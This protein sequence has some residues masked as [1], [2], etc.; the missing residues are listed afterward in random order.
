MPTPEPADAAS[1]AIAID[2]TRSVLVQA[3]AGSGKTTLLT[4]R[5]L[6]LL[7]R[8]EQPER[9]LALTFTRKAA[10]E[11][12]TRAL[13]A[14][15]AASRGDRGDLDLRS[16][17]LACA[18][19]RHLMERRID[20]S[21]NPTRLR[22][23]T[24]DGF[25]AWLAAQLPVTA[26][27]GGRI[28]VAED[29]LPYYQEAAAR[30][31]DG[32]AGPPF[33]RAIDRALELNDERWW[34]ARD[35]IAS[36][37]GSR[38]RWLEW[39]AGR[40]H[41][42]AEFDEQ[43]E[44]EVRAALD[45]DLALL[46]E[47]QLERAAALIGAERLPEL[48]RLLAG[49][50]Q[51]LPAGSAVLGSWR[52]P[53]AQLAP[54]AALVLQWRE[55]ANLV[56]TG[57]N[58]FRKPTALNVTLGFPPGC[59]DK[60][61]MAGLIEELARIPEA[62]E[63]LAAVRQLPEDR[64]DDAQWERVRALSRVLILGAAELERVFRQHAVADF[65][66]VF[67]A[68]LQ[69]LGR[70]SEP[71][72]LALLLDHRIEHILVDEFQDTS[73]AQLG[74]FRLLTAG[75]ESGD[76]RTFFC[77]GDPMQSI[78]GFREAEVR[79]FLDLA[80][81]GLGAVKLEPVRLTSNFRAQAPLV[82]WVNATF[83]RVFPRRDDRHRGAIAFTPA[84][85]MAR[86]DEAAAG[87]HARSFDTPAH[88]AAFIAATLAGM[89][90]E[91]GKLRAAI[92]VRQ[93]AHALPIIEA[94]GARGLAFRALD[95]GR[96][97]DTAVV[98]DII[99]LTRALLHA[100]D[101]IAWFALLRGPWVGLDLADLAT[102]AE[103]GAPPWEALQAESTLSRLGS[104]GAARAR[105]FVATMTQGFAARDQSGFARWV[106]RVWLALGGAS[107]HLETVDVANARRAFERLAELEKRGMVDPAQVE[108][109][110]ADL[111]PADPGEQAIEI[112]TIHKSKGLEFDAVFVPRLEA[113][114]RADAGGFLLA[115]A[116]SR[117]DRAG[118]VLAARDE[119]G[120]ES[121][122]LVEF[123]R[124]CTKEA[125]RLEAQRLLYV[126]CTRARRELH[127]SGCTER[128]DRAADAPFTPESSS[129][130][131]VLWPIMEARFEPTDQAL[132]PAADETGPP[133]NRLPANWVPPVLWTPSVA[134]PVPV[135]APAPPFDWAGETA[136][137]VGVRVHAC[138]QRLRV[139]P[140]AAAGV[141][142]AR[143]LHARWFEARGVPVQQIEGAVDRV[144]EALLAVLGDDRGRWILQD[145]RP[146]E[147]RELALTAR[148]EGQIINVVLDRTFVLEGERWVIDYKTSVHVGGQLDS[149]LDSELQRYAPQLR[150]YAQVARRL[151]PEPVRV[152]LYFPLLRAFREWRG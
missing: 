30:A 149:F 15:R 109:A 102:L 131:R 88:E 129:L 26:G 42:T 29:C 51:R 119:V 39:L 108:A 71:T 57:K 140:Q 44:R 89:L 19:H 2:P 1:R 54:R 101:R 66:A 53:P 20:L 150:R 12:R 43:H 3:P 132:A 9:I 49:A 33:R 84:V 144:I 121:D 35:G 4:Q 105:R 46:I 17:E 133:L 138:L 67:L 14:L 104:D 134:E 18:A 81:E 10:A 5:L 141:R 64:Y 24:I 146:G 113:K 147:D 37:L 125:Q 91:G 86:V 111:F 139:H 135:P 152:A 103:G 47:R 137:Q 38:S 151:G 69:A 23:Q 40:L 87:A 94:L 73:D 58:E 50:G 76:G 110:F 75:W 92:L 116:F 32:E 90:R 148:I 70:E 83:A 61:P 112:M 34:V 41:A 62:R 7:A 96:L 21:E 80:Q 11:M 126:A 120:E 100:D 95:I 59:D 99:M 60:R 106:E 65:Q 13:D 114:A 79:V 16:W 82:D 117:E 52:D 45:E 122:P 115:H 78:Y 130:M 118:F 127:L 25:C 93:K 143:A 48:H 124:H 77:V 97:Q 107:T 136:R 27:A 6:A 72:D 98:S 68:A 123:L 31:L 28:D 85:S 8:V 55:L 56:L 36:M 22:I 128:R 74:L 63:A 142:A 145:G